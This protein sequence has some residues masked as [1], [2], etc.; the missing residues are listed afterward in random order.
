MRKRKYQQINKVNNRKLT[1]TNVNYINY[2]KS[3][4]VHQKLWNSVTTGNKK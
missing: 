3:L 4:W 2:D 1:A